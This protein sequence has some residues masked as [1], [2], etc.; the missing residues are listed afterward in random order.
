MTRRSWGVASTSGA[1]PATPHH[2]AWR[3]IPRGRG[4]FVRGSPWTTGVDRP[5]S[6]A[7]REGFEPSDPCGSPV[8]KTGAFVRSATA[9]LG[10]VGGRALWAVYDLRRNTERC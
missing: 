7:E 5:A 10:I 8:F 6:L 4:H 2:P 1:T 9:P 3:P